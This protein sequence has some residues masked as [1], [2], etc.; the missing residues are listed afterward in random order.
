ML[1]WL[2]A[3][4]GDI[5]TKRVLPAILAESGSRLAGVVTSD[6]AKAAP[7][8][9]PAWP[10]LDAAL[11]RCEATAVYVA[12]P[13]FLHA[14]QTIAALRS[15]RHV[16]CEKP[17][18]L[19]YAEAESMCQA[20][21]QSHRTLGVAYY[22]RMYRKVERARQLIAAGAVGRPVFAEATSHAWFYPADGRRA[23][24]VDPALAGGGPLYDIASHRIDLMNY[25]FGRP[26]RL[27]GQLS[28]LLHPIDVEDNATV[29]IEYE[30]GV[31]GVVDVRWHS[32]ILR[33]EF[34]IRGTDG[35]IDLTPLNGDLLVHPGGQEQI[36]EH[37]NL[38]YPCIE[39]FAAAVLNGKPPRST[40]ATE[41][42][43]EW[44]MSEVRRGCGFICR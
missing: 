19:N 2:V 26:V 41:L 18:A 4:I 33:D 37:G 28:T 20:A 43:A 40:G 7:Y 13:V 36:P 16:L 30:G 23:W 31:R 6:P 32:R 12:T 15:G 35:E 5:A 21:E 10:D 14:R 29:M 11:A 44:V 17:M 38:H 39:D 9:V 42:E 22:R 25:F 34:R 1:D 27:S 8:G 3:G 24:L